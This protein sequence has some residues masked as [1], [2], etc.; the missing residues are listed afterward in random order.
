MIEHVLT[1]DKGPAPYQQ[2]RHYNLPARHFL[3][4]L[5]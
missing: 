4:A 3:N 2:L 5:T 1:T